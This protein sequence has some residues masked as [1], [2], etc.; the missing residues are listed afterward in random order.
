MNNVGI[1]PSS[2][3]ARS[4]RVAVSIIV[5]LVAL[6]AVIIVICQ[7]VHIARQPSSNARSSSAGHLCP[8]F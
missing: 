4:F 8:A 5:G 6:V 2:R 7:I 3:L 1:D